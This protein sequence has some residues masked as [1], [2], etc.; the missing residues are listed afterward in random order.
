MKLFHSLILSFLLVLAPVQIQATSQSSCENGECIPNLVTRLQNLSS[1]YQTKCLPPA[2]SNQQKFYTENGIT[3]ECW[4][5]ITE[6][7]HLE[8][9]LQGHKDRLEG[10][11]GCQSGQC[12]QNNPSQ[13]LVAQIGDLSQLEQN[14]TC[15]ETKKQQIRSACGEE[16]TCVLASS[17]L[18]L[19]AGVGGYIAEQLLPDK[20]K[21]NNCHLGHDSCVTQFGTA[22]LNTVVTFFSGAWDLLKSAKRYAKKKMGE[23]WT[24]VKGAENHSSSSQLAMAKASKSPE[25]FKLLLK[26]F[27]KTMKNIWQALVGAI[28]EWL[29]NDIFCQK[30]EGVPRFSKC[31]APAERFDCLTCKSM[32]SGLCGISGTLM[33]EIVPAFLTGGLVTAAKY[34]AEG[35]KEIAKSFRISGKGLE[36]IKSSSVGRMALE[37]STRVDEALKISRGLSATKVAIQS[38]LALTGKYLLSPARKAVK[39]SLETLTRLSEKGTMYVMESSAGK[40][41][42]FS[43]NAVKKTGQILIYPIENPMTVWFYHA[44]QRSFDKVFKL[45]APSLAAKTS[46]VSIL[47]SNQPSLDAT[48]VRLEHARVNNPQNIVALESELVSAVTPKR[49][50]LTQEVLKNSDVEFNLLV[51]NLYPELQYGD[52]AR[53]LPPAKVLEAEEQLYRAI[54]EMGDSETKLRL[55]SEFEAHRASVAR[56]AIPRL[57]PTYERPVVL[58]NAALDDEARVA[59]ALE[60]AGIDSAKLTPE[61]KSELGLTVLRAHHQGDGVVYQYS[62]RDLREKTR[63]LREGGFSP[64]QADKLIRSGLAGKIRPEDTYEKLNTV[65]VDNLGPAD[66]RLI[67]S[68]SEYAS[69]FKALSESDQLKLAKALRHLENSGLSVVDSA[70]IYKKYQRQFDFVLRSSDPKSDSASYLAEIIRGEQKAGHTDEVILNKLDDAFKGCK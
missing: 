33:A 48:Y 13:N 66:L 70:R 17:A 52:L 11:N 10:M 2:G 44:G 42:L 29:K 8:G 30:W 64:E 60:T 67:S 47:T 61:K 68:S 19:G 21:L 69:F 62:Q 31:L 20:A 53:T 16:L 15:S 39:A 23:F 1:V 49:T 27:P 34:G 24:W 43:Q 51:K 58:Q 5:L 57:T 6:V 56:S 37:T 25:I 45:G 38:A 36:S 7:K 22:F 63:I 59:K 14:P 3:E 54:H 46:T 35:A 55:I 50:E 9:Q 12:Q 4:R 28:K 65:V 41:L 40:V 26:D 32:A 18:S